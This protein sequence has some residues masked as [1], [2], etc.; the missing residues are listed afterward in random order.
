[1]LQDNN[2][3]PYVLYPQ[4]SFLVL[5]LHT[6][7]QLYRNRLNH[8]LYMLF[9]QSVF[10]SSADRELRTVVVFALLTSKNYDFRLL[11]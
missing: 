7:H 10:L 3:L 4:L 5:L 6:H 11:Q 9:L 1:M 8:T 2:Y